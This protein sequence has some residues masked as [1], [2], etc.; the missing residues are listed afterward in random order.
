VSNSSFE[1]ASVASE[2][3]ELLE[4]MLRIVAKMFSN[5]TICTFDRVT[6]MRNALSTELDPAFAFFAVALAVFCLKPRM[7]IIVTLFTGSANASVRYLISRSSSS[8]L[9]LYGLL[10][11]S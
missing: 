4:P 1:L 5:F 10:E 9:M 3:S 6:S 8:R 2:R 7:K 11:V